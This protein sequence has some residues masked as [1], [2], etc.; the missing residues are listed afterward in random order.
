MMWKNIDVDGSGII[1]FEVDCILRW[2]ASLSSPLH[3]AWLLVCRAC[4]AYASARAR[5]LCAPCCI[6]EG[7]VVPR[8]LQ[9]QLSR[10]TRGLHPLAG[11]EFKHVETVW[12]ALRA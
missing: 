12:K 11:G 1:G 10:I 5:A 2:V 7:R 3:L 8:G 9:N 4:G 6:E